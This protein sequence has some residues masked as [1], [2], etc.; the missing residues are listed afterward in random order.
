VKLTAEE[1]AEVHRAFVAWGNAGRYSL[2]IGPLFFGYLLH[3]IFPQV[4]VIWI[5]GPLAMIQIPLFL[6]LP[7]YLEG[8]GAERART[9]CRRRRLLQEK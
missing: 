1:E 5:G 7:E 2:A 4:D 6:W 8:V 3:F 9:K